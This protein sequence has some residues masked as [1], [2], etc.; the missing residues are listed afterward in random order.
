MAPS[1]ANETAS[2]KTA[3]TRSKDNGGSA[4]LGRPPGMPP[5][6]VPIVSVGRCNRATATD[7]TAIAIS[8]PGQCGLS[9]RRAKITAIVS[10]AVATVAGLIVSIAA[11]RA[12][13]LSRKGPGSLPSSVIPRRSRSWL[14][15]MITAMPA[16]KPTVTG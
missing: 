6:R 10:A 14:A 13:I 9:L 12:V 1:S 2:G 15:K 7:A 3:A 4:G 8:M 16:V 5:K 11:A